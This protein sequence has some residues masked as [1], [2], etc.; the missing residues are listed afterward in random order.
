MKLE[1]AIRA[2][3]QQIRML[4]TIIQDT[5]AAIV[6]L[7]TLKEKGSGLVPLGAGIFIPVEM[8]EEKAVVSAGA[9]IFMEKS[10]EEA[11]SLLERRKESAKKALAQ[12]KK[13]HMALIE[14]AR[15]VSK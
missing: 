12:T 3:D 2:I 10:I 8:K 7:K 13:Q 11:V 1:D 5:E 15:R 6:A 4:T 14:Q 9:N